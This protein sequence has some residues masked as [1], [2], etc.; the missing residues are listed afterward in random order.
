M[1]AQT[2]CQVQE[3]GLSRL[4]SLASNATPRVGYVKLHQRRRQG[5]PE[6]ERCDH[7]P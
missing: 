4:R 3:L 6:H 5:D 2:S 1:E 7:E